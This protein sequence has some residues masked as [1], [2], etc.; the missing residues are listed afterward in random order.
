MR[1][2]KI[3]NSVI[4]LLVSL[5]A[6]VPVCA[7][8][9]SGRMRG[10]STNMPIPITSDGDHKVSYKK[11]DV[12]T[13]SPDSGDIA[14][15]N[16]RFLGPNG[17]PTPECPANPQSS[18]P[19]A[20]GMLN[21]KFVNEI[22]AQ[23]MCPD[24]CLKTRTGDLYGNDPAACPSGYAIK[25]FFNMQEEWIRDPNPTGPVTYEPAPTSDI[26]TYLKY[27][28]NVDGYDCKADLAG[29]GDSVCLQA[30]VTANEKFMTNTKMMHDLYAKAYGAQG[31][32]NDGSL[33]YSFLNPFTVD[34]YSSH[35][36]VEAG[37]AL[38]FDGVRSSQRVPA[39]W[40]AYNNHKDPVNVQRGVYEESGNDVQE[41]PFSS[42]QG[43]PEIITYADPACK[44]RA[45]RNAY[46]EQS[47]D[48]T[49]DWYVQGSMPG[50]WVGRCDKIYYKLKIPVFGLHCVSKK[51][52]RLKATGNKIPTSLICGR[53]KVIWQ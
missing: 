34:N 52:K 17:S 8:A 41:C 47:T 44:V 27:Y 15:E 13:D 22:T 49:D 9:E 5:M 38:M 11:I 18:C 26:Q 39:T 40:A 45:K 53:V 48:F 25:A 28:Y 33:P 2:G 51:Q 42:C 36:E 35:Q 50:N 46:C 6:L 1:M 43:L 23:Q 14:N 4:L 31:G 21:G 19:D 10:D 30:P 7:A 24:V 3:A 16:Y 37:V 32:N 29:Y 20:N 12:N